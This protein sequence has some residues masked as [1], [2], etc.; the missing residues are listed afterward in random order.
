MGGSRRV[1]RPLAALVVERLDKLE[2][3]LRQ[4]SALL[5]FNSP[6]LDPGVWTSSSPPFSW[7]AAAQPFVPAED[8]YVDELLAAGE[9]HA[10]TENG[11]TALPDKQQE[12]GHSQPAFDMTPLPDAPLE[13][14]HAQPENEPSPSEAKDELEHYCFSLR[15]TLLEWRYRD[16]FDGGDKDKIAKALQ[17]TLGW[18]S[19]NQ[20][21]D[22]G[23]FEA[24]QKELE[25][26][27]TPIMTKV[28][29]AEEE[30]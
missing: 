2:A 29:Q 26:V 27:V 20:L 5:A 11:L 10:R 16:Y 8:A 24:K 14:G 7:N 28:Y 22:K 25:G 23:E 18:L 13:E 4:L 6:G 21:A 9:D 17:D 12:E 15:G 30:E 1:S 3:H 19:Q